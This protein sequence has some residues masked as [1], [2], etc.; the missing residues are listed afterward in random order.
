[1]NQALILF[2]PIRIESFGDET[3]TA[4]TAGFASPTFPNINGKFHRIDPRKNNGYYFQGL[5]DPNDP[6]QPNA[7][8]QFTAQ[9]LALGNLGVQGNS[10]RTVCCGPGLDNTDLS[11][12]KNTAINERF[13]T[14]FRL[15][16]FN[17]FNHT[18]FINPDGTISDGS[19]FGLVKG[20]GP[21]RLM[22]VALKLFF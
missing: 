7:N 14:E 15:D 20:V 16:V 22:Q 6:T 9:T 8:P 2:T 21:P 3:L 11:L 18:K 4:V 17:A 1:M 19:N 5:V 10:P 13:R 12:Q